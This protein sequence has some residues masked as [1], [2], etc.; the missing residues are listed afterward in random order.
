MD[1]SETSNAL[2]TYDENNT[3]SKKTFILA[4]TEGNKNKSVARMMILIFILSFSLGIV[5]TIFAYN[6]Q[7]FKSIVKLETSNKSKTENSNELQRM[8][9]TAFMKLVDKHLKNNLIVKLDN[10]KIVRNKKGLSVRDEQRLRL[11]MNGNIPL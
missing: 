10:G 5:S 11:F 8:L 3:E 2:N 9:N 7:E 6:L 4:K 1:D